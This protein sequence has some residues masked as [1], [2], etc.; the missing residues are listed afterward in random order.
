MQLKNTV[1]TL[2]EPY[3]GSRLVKPVTPTDFGGQGEGPSPL[4][5]QMEL[6]H[7]V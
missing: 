5:S 2:N 3:L 6:S 7:V 4:N 1:V